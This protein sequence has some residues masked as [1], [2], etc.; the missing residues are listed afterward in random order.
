MNLERKK[1]ELEIS[2]VKC[3]MQEME[4]KIF[5]RQEEIKRLEDNMLNQQKR[6]DE[7]LKEIGE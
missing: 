5:E 4:L 3:A 6:I 2:K 7:L 1:K